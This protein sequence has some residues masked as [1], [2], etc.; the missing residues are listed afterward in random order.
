M[1]IGLMGVE[2]KNAQDFRLSQEFLE[3]VRSR[4]LRFGRSLIFFLDGFKHFMPV[5][6]DVPGSSDAHF[7]ISRSQA[8]DGNLDFIPDDE[9]FT[10]FARKD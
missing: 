1:E 7:Y 8:Q 2:G 9:A 4:D 10:L 6:R 5:N 3:K